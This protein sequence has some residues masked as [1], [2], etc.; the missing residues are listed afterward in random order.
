MVGYT[1]RSADEWGR[2][3]MTSAPGISEKVETQGWSP[4]GGQ[5]A[6]LRQQSLHGHPP[7]TFCP[8]FIFKC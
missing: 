3:T 8:I 4:P 6:L 5:V 2:E 1:G 7:F